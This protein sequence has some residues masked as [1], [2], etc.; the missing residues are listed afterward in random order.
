ERI[1]IGT[2]VL[3]APHHPVLE[4]ANSLASLDNLSGGRLTVGVGVGW[5]EG[6]FG[7]LG[8]TFRDRGKRLDEIL[9]V[10]H[11]VW[12][13]APGCFDGPTVSFEDLRILPKPAHEIPIW[14]G[15]NGERAYR[16]AIER[17]DGFHLIGLTPEETVAPIATLRAARP[18]PSFTISLRTGWDP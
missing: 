17:G 7:A 13:D 4:L 8:Q 18:D 5:S 9:A 10:W 15:G 11:T 6:E 12:H 14:V 2:S 1:G 3:V 16:R